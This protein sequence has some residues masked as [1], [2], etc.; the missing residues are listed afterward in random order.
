MRSWVLNRSKCVQRLRVDGQGKTGKRKP[1]GRAMLRRNGFC[2]GQVSGREG[3]T[4]REGKTSS[5]SW[6]TKNRYVRCRP[7]VHLASLHGTCL[8]LGARAE[9]ICG[10]LL[11][12]IVS[13]LQASRQATASAEG[14]SRWW[15]A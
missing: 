13:I 1:M 8:K 9:A 12:V 14:T 4:L 10:L 11:P 7:L 6:A 3:R 2:K 5:Y 15:L